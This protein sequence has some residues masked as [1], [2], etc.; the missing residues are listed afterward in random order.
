MSEGSEDSDRQVGKPDS[1]KAG[2][3]GDSA[4]PSASPRDKKTRLLTTDDE[5]L[6]PVLRGRPLSVQDLLVAG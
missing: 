1:S 5:T 2:E 3:T 4:S 6:V